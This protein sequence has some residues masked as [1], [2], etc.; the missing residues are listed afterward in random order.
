MAECARDCRRP[1]VPSLAGCALHGLRCLM[2]A[3]TNAAGCAAL[4]VQ[5]CSNM[6]AALRSPSPLLCCSGETLQSCKRETVKGWPI[7]GHGMLCCSSGSRGFETPLGHARLRIPDLHHTFLQGI[8]PHQGPAAAPYA[9]GELGPSPLLHP[10]VPPGWQAA[11]GGQPAEVRAAVEAGAALARRVRLCRR[12]ISPPRLL[13]A[14]YLSMHAVISRPPPGLPLL[15]ASLGTQPGSSG[16][17]C[18]ASTAAAPHPPA[19]ARIFGSGGSASA[20]QR[21]GAAQPQDH[22]G[23]G[24]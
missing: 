24:G 13:P 22:A 7:G 4:A 1:G 15:Q 21:H 2:C 14:A 5:R 20:A 19:G 12:C 16:G 3:A 23:G 8:H 6:R 9:A 10:A 11:R 17:G 18:G